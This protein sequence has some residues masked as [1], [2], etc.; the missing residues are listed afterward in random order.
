MDERTVTITLN[1]YR[2]LIATAERY[3]LLRD[4][5]ANDSYM[6]KED[7][8]LYGIENNKSESEG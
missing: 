1:E 4:I 7:R 5:H 6:S 2:E 8:K 3:R